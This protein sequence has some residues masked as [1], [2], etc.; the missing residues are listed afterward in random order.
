MKAI[1]RLKPFLI[2]LPLWFIP[3]L[4]TCQLASAGKGDE[5]IKKVQSK[6]QSL[7]TLSLKFS[8]QSQSDQDSSEE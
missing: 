2:L 8:V 5:I 4:L 3:A 6:Y 7:K 1:P